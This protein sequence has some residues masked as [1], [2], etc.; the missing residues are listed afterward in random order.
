MAAGW[1][2][3]PPVSDP[4]ATGAMRAATAAA[5]PPLEPP[6]MRSN[7]QGLR[8]GPKAE[9]SVDD[10]IAN[11]SQLVLPI[12]M[13]PAATRRSMT[14]ASYGGSY[15]SRIFEPAVVRVRRVQMLS[16]IATGT[17]SRG[18]CGQ[19]VRSLSSSAARFSA[20]SLVTV[21]NALTRRSACSIRS[22]A[23]VTTSTADA[24]PDRIAPVM[25]PMRSSLSI[26]RGLVV[27]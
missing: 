19:R 24:L 15:R 3:E 1:R 8:V 27:P 22:S 2:T 18:S 23:A 12:G 26:T 10:P 4:S 7:A 16:L 5:E 20:D 25:S 14:V 21:R 13:A 9:F 6:G 11:S 17:P